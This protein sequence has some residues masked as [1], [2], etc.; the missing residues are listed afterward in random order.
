MNILQVVMTYLTDATGCGPREEEYH[1]MIF[2]LTS[3]RFKFANIFN[4]P[5][6]MCAFFI[7]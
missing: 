5:C 2:L 7:M 3:C 6:I 4:R 1:P